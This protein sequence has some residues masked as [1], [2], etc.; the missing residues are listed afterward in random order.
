M[1]DKRPVVILPA[2]PYEPWLAATP[3]ESFEFMR[4]Y[5][6]ELLTMSPEPLPPK[7]KKAA[8]PPTPMP[9]NQPSLL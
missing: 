9:P 8:G 3:Q 2:A 7:E 6:A 4:Q 5:P 1:Q